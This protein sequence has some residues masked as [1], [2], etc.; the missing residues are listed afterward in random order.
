[1]TVATAGRQDFD[2]LVRRRKLIGLAFLAVPV[3]IVGVF[4]VAEGIGGE[5]GWWGHLIQLA[6]GLGLAAGVWRY[7]RIGG[8]LLIAA[9][10]LLTGI[11]LARGEGVGGAVSSAG[12]LSIP[13]IVAGVFFTLAGYAGRT[14]AQ[15]SP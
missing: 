14:G 11:L 10:I 4:A 13:L 8:P 12:L 1:M 3:V 5:A 7:P 6:I 15:G 9:G 2:G